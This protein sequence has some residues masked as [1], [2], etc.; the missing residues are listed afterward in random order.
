MKTYDTIKRIKIGEDSH[1]IEYTCRHAIP[2]GWDIAAYGKTIAEGL[3]W[4]EV[5]ATILKDWQEVMR[6]T[7]EAEHRERIKDYAAYERMVDRE[8][9]QMARQSGK[10]VSND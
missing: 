2:T 6:E 9:F 4:Q 5:Y 3:L 1:A 10:G 8:A 7:H